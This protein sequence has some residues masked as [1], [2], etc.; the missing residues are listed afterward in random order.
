MAR[1]GRWHGKKVYFGL[2]YDL[3][4]NE[5][6]TELGLR[7]DP[8]DLVR[9]LREVGADFVQTD[10]KGHPGMTSWFSRVK[11]AT[12][13]PGVKRDVLAAWCKVARKLKLP[14]HCHYSGIWDAAAAKAHPD[15]AVVRR[16]AKRVKDA[17][18][19]SAPTQPSEKMCPRGPYVEKLMIPQLL[20]LID[21]YHVD[22]FWVDGD[23][24]AVEPCYCRRCRQEFTRRTGI[25]EP[26]SD[27]K[28]TNWPAWMQ[29][30]RE[31]FY[32]YVMKYCDAV[33]AH[34]DGV[35]VC[36][37]WAQ[38][39]KDPG[40]P[41]V[42]TDWIS[43]DTPPVW[44]MDATRCEARFIST[45]G[46]PWDLM[47][48]GFYATQG[49]N[50]KDS[51]WQV[52]PV[53]ML[54]QEA[55]VAL[56]LGG[57]VQ[58]Y[59]SPEGLRDGRFADWRI[60]RLGKVGR[61]VK[62]RRA[63]CQDT[64]TFAQV[65]VLHS[66][67][68][69]RKQAFHNLHWGPDVTAVRG[70]VFALLENSLGVDMLDEWALLRRLHEFPLVV[71]PEQ[72]GLS[73]EMVAALRKYVEGGGRLL[74]TGSASLERFGEEFLGVKGVRVEKEARYYIPALDGN[75]E[76]FSPTWGM[77]TPTTARPLARLGTS[78]H[79]TDK[80]TEFPSAVV[81]KWGKG[82]VVYAPF[83][84][85]RHFELNGY[86][87]T[88]ALIGDLVRALRPTFDLRVQAPA[89][90]DVVLRKKARRT[91]VHLIN[92]STGIPD[93]P[94]SAGVDEIPRVGP[95]TVR[96]RR[97]AK[98]RRVRETLEG[99]QLSWRYTRGV[100]GGTLRIEL[101]SVHLHAAVVVE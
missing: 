50:R 14:L 25:A 44:G 6:D 51:P 32:E 68:H 37:N 94:K 29:F 88:R 34:K 81:Q 33:H 49:Y 78:C 98:P 92:R 21:R 9:W 66:E 67:A 74:V 53:Q 64:E 89:A 3:H 5:R 71:A 47:L 22:G 20:E 2:H 10:C 82:R 12:V 73:D 35:L 26:P 90:V 38:T 52:K 99:G 95:V 85:F 1:S 62:R 84:L 39:F 65:A 57:N 86:P 100:R 76:V 7:L 23:F 17:Q 91:I 93:N 77:V 16:P 54:M 18:D 19:Q 70:A 101:P 96:M 36:S 60:K 58:M 28:D 40:P 4:A 13:S 55:A 97:L 31:S 43:G 75:T 27:V 41:V 42:P 15:W 30:H 72:D 87:L 45:R 11:H 24:W 69:L 83:D 46:K 61:F 8:D 80:L 59:E 79:L 56:A 63:G 48:W